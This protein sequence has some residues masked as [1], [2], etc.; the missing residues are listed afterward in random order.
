MMSPYTNNFQYSI[1]PSFTP[2][3]RLVTLNSGLKLH[4]KI[5]DGRDTSLNGTVNSQINTMTTVM[6]RYICFLAKNVFIVIHRGRFSVVGHFLYHV[7]TS[8]QCRI[9]LIS[10]SRFVKN[11]QS[12][13]PQIIQT[14]RHRHHPSLTAFR[15]QFNLT[16]VGFAQQVKGLTRNISNRVPSKSN[17]VSLSK[18]R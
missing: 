6:I 11:R 8:M 16:R 13:V 5:T 4:D 2:T 12:Q 3:H 7:I 1:N 17:N 18:K 9:L 14:S 15:L 10:P